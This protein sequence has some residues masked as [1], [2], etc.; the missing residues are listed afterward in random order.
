MTTDYNYTEVDE[1]AFILFMQDGIE[2]FLASDPILHHMAMI[3]Y[4]Q[5]LHRRWIQMDNQEK[6]PFMERARTQ[7]R[8]L[9]QQLRSE[10]LYRSIL[11]HMSDQ[12]THRN[13][14]QQPQQPP[15]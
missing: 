14:N 6:D 15:H 2:Y 1:R 9:R 8:E 13:R 7:M 10:Y 4:I 3:E 12:D 5:R 11:R